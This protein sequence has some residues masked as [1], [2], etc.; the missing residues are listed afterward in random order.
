MLDITI[1]VPYDEEWNGKKALENTV[2]SVKSS[3]LN[4]L[5]ISKTKLNGVK[6]IIFDYKNVWQAFN[7]SIIEDYPALKMRDIP[8]HSR[9]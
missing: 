9:L 5:V 6:R 8:T 1:V 4:Y 7:K 3:G 2:K